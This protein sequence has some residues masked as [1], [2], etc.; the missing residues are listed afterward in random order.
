MLG[1]QDGVGE[2]V[3]RVG[4]HSLDGVDHLVEANGVGDVGRVRHVVNGRLTP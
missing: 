3:Q 1:R 4:V 2:L